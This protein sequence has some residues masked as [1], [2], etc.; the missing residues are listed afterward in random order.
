MEGKT[1]GVQKYY[2]KICKKFYVKRVKA[3]KLFKIIFI[4]CT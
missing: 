4:L 3:L 2:T 1:G